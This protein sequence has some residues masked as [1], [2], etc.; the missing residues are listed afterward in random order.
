MKKKLVIVTVIALLAVAALATV[1]YFSAQDTATNVITTGN[2]TMELHEYQMI[3]GEMKPYPEGAVAAMP[4]TVISKI[5]TIKNTGDNAFY[6]R[7]KVKVTFYADKDLKEQV[8][9]STEYVSCDITSDWIEGSGG[10]YYYK[11]I[12][13]PNESVVLF[14]T[15][16]FEKSMPNDYQGISVKVDIFAQAVQVKNNENID[17]T[18][19]S[20]W[21][22]E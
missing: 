1:A 20:G 12:V 3:D 21:P 2:V 14:K 17:T 5:P 6:T 7:A 9:L 15:V 8:N 13:E 22:Q 16:S 10:W 11:G 19:V 4:G 18:Q